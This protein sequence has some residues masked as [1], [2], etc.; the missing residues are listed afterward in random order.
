M[1][2]NLFRKSA[3]PDAAYEAYSAIVAQ[4]RQVQ[5]YALW[6]VPDTV[7]GR[8]DMISLH[9]ALLLRR[10][11]GETSARQFGQSVVEIFFRDMDRSLREM[12]VTDLGVPGKV[13]KMGNL[14]YGL[15]AAV[16]QAL[17]SAEPG[18]LEEVLLRN[19][20]AGAAGHEGQLAAYLR[21]EA[22]RLAAMPV[23]ELTAVGAP[24]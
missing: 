22:D 8:F 10:L 11:R 9:L 21:G 18:A 15:A 4:S 23:A 2:F 20:Y 3:A 12:G 5:F 17:D 13:R 16:G 6:G 24:A 19:I 7:T 14:F 1:I